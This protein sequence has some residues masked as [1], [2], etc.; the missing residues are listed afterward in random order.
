MIIILHGNAGSDLICQP[1][2]VSNYRIHAHL[3]QSDWDVSVS[4]TSQSSSFHHP[5]QLFPI[6]GLLAPPLPHVVVSM[7]IYI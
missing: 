6:V 2:G 4:D 1:K 7:L 3:K 5:F